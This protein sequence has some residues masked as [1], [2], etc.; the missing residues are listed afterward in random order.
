MSIEGTAGKY[1]HI[2]I[3]SRSDCQ[4]SIFFALSGNQAD[5][6]RFIGNAI[7]SGATA[8]VCSSDWTGNTQEQCR[9]FWVVDPLS[10]L[11]R[12][13]KH[14][15]DQFRAP[16]VAVAGSVGKTTTKEFLL[17]IF[18]GKYNEVIATEGSQNGYVGIPLSLLRLNRNTDIGII[19]IGIDEPGAMMKHLE[20]V[21]P[22]IGLI[23]AIAPEHL[24]TL[25]N[26]ETIAFEEGLC[27][28]WLATNHGLVCLNLDDPYLSKMLKSLGRLAGTRL[29]SYG[30]S[31]GIGPH[32]HLAGSLPSETPVHLRVSGLGSDTT[33]E[34]PIPGKH[35]AQNLLGAICVANALGLSQEQIKA[36]LILFAAPA[37]RFEIRKLPAGALVVCDYYNASPASMQASIATTATLKDPS[38]GK[39]IACLGD[40]LELGSEEELFHRNLAEILCKNTFAEI[41]CLGEKMKWLV[42]ELNR[43]YSSIK[44]RHFKD[45]NMISEE[46]KNITDARH[47]VILIKGSRSMKM[48][49]VWQ[50]LIGEKTEG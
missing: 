45:H 39:L 31:H 11:R 32:Q 34:L 21:R 2:S 13:A 36:G 6:H 40:M 48:E 23:T 41:L 10:A 37:G 49:L 35:N 38:S 7:K 46:L 12:L 5:G 3:D 30:F 33:Y 42:D 8:I 19:E 20:L 47:D 25:G 43:N 16:V 26:M 14:W 27:L 9:F 4:N 44:C 1:T 50:L 17:A 24:E 18:K 28:D 15:R 22:T 29:F